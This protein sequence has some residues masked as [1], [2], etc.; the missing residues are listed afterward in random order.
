MTD[1]ELLKVVYT[2]LDL[3][4][5]KG[6]NE[7]RRVYSILDNIHKTTTRDRKDVVHVFR[8]LESYKALEL[9]STT[10]LIYM[11]NDLSI[12][13]L[14]NNLSKGSITTYPMQDFFQLF[15][16]IE[17]R[18]ATF[19]PEVRL[20][21]LYAFIRGYEVALDADNSKLPSFDKLHGFSRFLCENFSEY[22]PR[23]FIWYTILK[24]EF[25]AGLNGFNEFFEY[26]WRFRLIEEQ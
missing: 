21:H 1:T 25:G 18:P 2:Q 24:N 13:D 5:K 20:D 4:T 6:S 19:L 23:T 17:R 10:P 7:I 14:A 22:D 9:K 8:T 12:E 26:L 16:L 11:I 3:K 15:D